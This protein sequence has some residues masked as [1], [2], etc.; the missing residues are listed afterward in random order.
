MSK[1]ERVKTNSESILNIKGDVVPQVDPIDPDDEDLLD[2]APM[3]VESGGNPLTIGDVELG[4]GDKQE[5][6]VEELAQVVE[7]PVSRP[8]LINNAILDDAAEHIISI[9]PMYIQDSVRRLLRSKYYTKWQLV[10]GH[11][12]RAYNS[13]H[14]AEPTI[15]PAWKNRI[16]SLNLTAS[17]DTVRCKNPGCKKANFTPKRLGQEYCSNE[18]GKQ[19]RAKPVAKPSL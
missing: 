9:L 5:D 17:S 14:F 16:D 4:P 8:A 7:E 19:H 13:T 11:L 6:V 12:I 2:E 1:P 3:D 18:C 15:D 10:A